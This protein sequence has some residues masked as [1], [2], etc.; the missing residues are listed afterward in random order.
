MTTLYQ[1]I[2]DIIDRSPQLTQRGLAAALGVNPAAVNRMLYGQRRIRADELPVIEKYLGQKIG[3]ATASTALS[4]VPVYEF[5]QGLRKAV[6]WAKRHP[7]Q[8]D[9]DEAFAIYV[10]GDDMAPRYFQGELA[11]VHPGRPIESDRD[12]LIKM[13]SG[14]VIL[15]HILKRSDAKV[16]VRQFNPPLDKDIAAKDIAAIYA[17]VGRG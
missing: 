5:T 17:I 15:R 13:N 8:Q 11:Y 10:P 3:Q 4:P 6:D 9:V 7:T 16:K 14:D 12:A 1:Q 2:A